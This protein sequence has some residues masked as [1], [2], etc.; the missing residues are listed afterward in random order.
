MIG[1]R[2]RDSERKSRERERGCVSGSGSNHRSRVEL[3]GGPGTI[4]R[5][6]AT[7]LPR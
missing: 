3:Q 1:T 2:E 6:L 7:F 4:E 5:M